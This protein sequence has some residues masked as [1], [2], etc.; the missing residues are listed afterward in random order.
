ML[1]SIRKRENPYVKHPI[2]TISDENGS[3]FS[4]VISKGLHQYIYIDDMEI[5]I[6]ETEN[7]K[8]QLGRPILIVCTEKDG[9]NY[10]LVNLHAP[11]RQPGNVALQMELTGDC[12]SYHIRKALEKFKLGTEENAIL[13]NI[14]IMG[15]FNGYFPQESPFKFRNKTFSAVKGKDKLPRSCCYNFNSSCPDTMTSGKFRKIIEALKL[16][17]ESTLKGGSRKKNKS[18]K[19]KNNNSNSGILTRNRKL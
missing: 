8:A 18:K 15:D 9:K 6:E 1:F 19:R 16:K 13:D 14:F 7:F 11:N 4:G 2:Y 17:S 12:I 3:F 10:L 5:A